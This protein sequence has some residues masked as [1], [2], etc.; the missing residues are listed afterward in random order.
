MEYDPNDRI[1]FYPIFYLGKLTDTITLGKEA[2]RK[3]SN[4][5]DDIK[6]RHARNF[7]FA[8]NSKLKI[9]VD[10]AFKLT[11]NLNFKSFNEQ[12]KRIEIDSTR[13]YRSFMVVVQNLSDSL[14]S[15]GTFNNLEEIVRQAKDRSG[16]WVDIETPIE[17]YCATGARD[18]VLEPGEIAIAK[19]IRYKGNFKTE[20]RLKYS[21]WGRTLYSN[22]FTDYIDSKQFSVPINKDNY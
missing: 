19:L 11:Y 20:C 17:Y 3:N 2:T 4:T 13:S 16:N 10:T 1:G 22:S 12:S 18:V 21:K 5:Q 6:F 7:T 14:I 9:K 8:D 15:I